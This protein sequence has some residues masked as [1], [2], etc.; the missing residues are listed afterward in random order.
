MDG[1]LLAHQ[2]A[3]AYLHATG[4]QSQSC[5]QLAAIGDAASCNDGYIYGIHHLR[6]Q[7]HGSHFAHMAAAL[8]A[9]SND[10][11]DAQRLQMLCQHGG[12]DNR[13]H[14]DACRFPRGDIFARVACTG[15]HNG[16]ALFHHDL[17]KLICLRMHEHDVHAKR[18]VG[19]LFA[20]ADVLAQGVGI[21]AA[22]TDD[23]QRTRVG[24]GGGKL[25]GG[26]VGHAALNDG[27]FCA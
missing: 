24:A 22:R 19:Q 3:G 20:A 7:R 26:N 23:A 6:H 10:S 9:L 18:L 14:L 21:H 25:A 8:G 1:A 11:I 15:G 2:Q 12:G 27:V 17:G 16:H 5:C 13:D 4:T